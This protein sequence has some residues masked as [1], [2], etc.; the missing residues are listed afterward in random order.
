MVSYATFTACGFRQCAERRSGG[1]VT[2]YHHYPGRDH[3]SFDW[4]HAAGLQVMGEPQ[5]GG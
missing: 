2:E 5:L 4:V 1:D 3:G